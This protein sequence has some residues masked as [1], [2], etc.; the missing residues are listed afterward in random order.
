MHDDDSGD[1]DDTNIEGHLHCPHQSHYLY[2]FSIFRT[3]I[4]Y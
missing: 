1:D 3:Y 4:N 2:I